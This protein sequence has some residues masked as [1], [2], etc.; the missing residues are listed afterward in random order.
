MMICL[1]IGSCKANC[2]CRRNWATPRQV[3]YW[4]ILLLAFACITDV[5]AGRNREHGSQRV[6]VGSNG[7]GGGGSD[8]TMVSIGGGIRSRSDRLRHHQP[9]EKYP[10]TIAKEEQHSEFMKGKSESSSSCICLYVCLSSLTRRFECS[11]VL[12]ECNLI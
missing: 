1:P 3:Q 11:T 8:T 10:M 2:F 9:A 7:G 12:C 5:R 4:I 6:G